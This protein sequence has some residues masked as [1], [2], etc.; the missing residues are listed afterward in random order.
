MY[1]SLA[2]VFTL[3]QYVQPH[4][5]Y[6]LCWLDFVKYS[7]VDPQTMCLEQRAVKGLCEI[8]QQTR[9]TNF[10]T[11][12]RPNPNVTHAQTLTL[13]L[14]WTPTLAPEVNFNPSLTLTW[15]PSTPPQH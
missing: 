13:T 12:I 7:H 1:F 11:W 2:S 5:D 6:T 10:R 4:T 9:H 8:T 3:S 15:T 14:L